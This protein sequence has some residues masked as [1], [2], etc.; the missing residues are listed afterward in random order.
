MSNINDYLSILLKF[1]ITFK[2]IN[3]SK[4]NNDRSQI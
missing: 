1:D 3:E 4:F 2:I